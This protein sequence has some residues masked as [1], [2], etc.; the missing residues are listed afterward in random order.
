MNAV[1]ALTIWLVA[2]IGGVLVLRVGLNRQLGN[3]TVSIGALLVVAVSDFWRYVLL[4]WWGDEGPL[5][6]NPNV[7][8]VSV[9]VLVLLPIAR[10]YLDIGVIAESLRHGLVA[11]A[12]IGMSADISP[13]ALAVIS[14]LDIAETLSIAVG[15]AVMAAL[16]F[17]G[18]VL[19]LAASTYY[20]PWDYA[21]WFAGLTLIVQAEHPLLSGLNISAGYGAGAVVLTF[22]L[23]FFIYRVS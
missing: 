14:S 13:I 9:W 23:S 20:F 6:A 16:F 4:A 5:I 2:V 18:I 11:L 10:R 15:F 8:F 22:A 21:A 1:I 7:A 19:C 3:L 12:A 17:I